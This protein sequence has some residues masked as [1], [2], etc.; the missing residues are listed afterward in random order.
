MRR[1]LVVLLVVLTA[2]PGV[3]T[4]ADA[5]HS[6]VTWVE[7]N[8]A[9]GRCH[10]SGTFRLVA[11]CDDGRKVDSSWLT[12]RDGMGRTKVRCRTTAVSAVIEQRQPVAPVM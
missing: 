8:A 11:S 2:V 3:A 1:L 12:I 5:L 6:C 4:A 10:G 7:G 9:S